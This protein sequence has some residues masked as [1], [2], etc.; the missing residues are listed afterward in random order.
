VANND[1]NSYPIKLSE[2]SGGHILFNNILTNNSNGSGIGSISFENSNFVSNNNVVLDTFSIGGSS[3]TFNDWQNV[4][5]GNNSIL[6]TTPSD[7]FINMASNDYHQKSNSPSIDNGVATFSNKTASS[8]DIEN[9]SRPSG[10]GYDIGAY[11]R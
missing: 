11:E 4:G 10:N 9:N 8:A 3:Y 7:I 1:N 6:S 5:Y 2:E